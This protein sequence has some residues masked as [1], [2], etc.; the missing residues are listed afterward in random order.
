MAHVSG[1]QSRQVY[2]VSNIYDKTLRIGIALVLF[3][4]LDFI[5]LL[6]SIPNYWFPKVLFWWFIAKVD[7]KLCCTFPCFMPVPP[8][9]QNKTFLDKTLY[10]VYY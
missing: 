3:Q 4:R 8:P 2:V 7:T 10:L 9:P 1:F 6:G 5:F